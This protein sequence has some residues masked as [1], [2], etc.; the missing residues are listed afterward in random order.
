M[1]YAATLILLSLSFAATANPFPQGN[2]QAGQKLFEQLKCNSCHI[3]M[4]G[5]DGSAIFTRPNSKVHNPSQLLAQIGRCGGNVD[6]ELSAQEEQNIAAYLNR[7]Y[8]FKGAK[9]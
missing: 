4:F 7:Y 9:P 8:N 3:N 1:K 5:G 2:A 6:K